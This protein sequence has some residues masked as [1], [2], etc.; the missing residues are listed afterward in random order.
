MVKFQDNYVKANASQKK[1]LMIICFPL[2]VWGEYLII[3]SMLLAYSRMAM[4][5]QDFLMFFVGAFCLF[6]FS[7][8]ILS[9][10]IGLVTGSQLIKEIVFNNNELYLINALYKKKD[11]I[12]NN[13]ANIVDGQKRVPFKSNALYLKGCERGFTI[14][15]KNGQFYRVSPHMERIDELKAELEKIIDN[16]KNDDE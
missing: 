7:G 10:F 13:L 16:N 3:S 8:Y 6:M 1:W 11:I 14:N 12:K 15:L 9:G 2:I 5:N 4:F